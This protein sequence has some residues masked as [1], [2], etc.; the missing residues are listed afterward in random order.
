MNE[1]YTPVT[2]SE[3]RHF[4]KI[5]EGLPRE[6]VTLLQGILYR[7]ISEAGC[8]SDEVLGIVDGMTERFVE[9]DREMR[10]QLML[11]ELR[12]QGT[13]EQER[14][15]ADDDQ[16]ITAIKRTLPKFKSTRDWGGIYR[17]LVDFCDFPSVKTDFTQRFWRMGIYATDSPACL[18]GFTRDAPPAIYKEE[19]GDHPFGYQVMQR[20]CPANWPATYYEWQKRDLPNRDFE[21]R[22]L[23]ARLFLENL[24]KAVYGR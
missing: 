4:A 19:Y 7:R 15:E 10:R 14:I 5:A 20:G 11:G 9:E 6:N 12:L 1:A 23:I 3:A 17:I 22:K 13:L 2:R 8:E 24:R 16:I 21:D 18:E